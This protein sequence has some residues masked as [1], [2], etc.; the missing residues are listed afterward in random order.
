[1]TDRITLLRTVSGARLTKRWVGGPDKLEI[2]GYEDAKT[3]CVSEQEVHGIGSLSLVLRNNA[4]NYDRCVIRGAYRPEAVEKPSNRALRNTESTFDEPHHWCMIDVDGYEP[5]SADPVRE[6]AEAAAEFILDRLPKQFHDRSFYWQLSSSAGAPGNEGVLKAHLWFWLSEKCDSVALRSWAK[7]TPGVDPAV[8]RQVQPHYIADPVFVGVADPVPCRG[9]LVEGVLGDTVDI[10]FLGDTPPVQPT[11]EDASD[12]DLGKIKG[13]VPDYDIDRVRDEVLAHLDP[14]MHHDEWV[15][16]GM[17]LHHQFAGDPEALELWDEWS[18]DGASYNE[19]V[20]A[21]RWRSFKVDRTVG[22]GSVTLGSL[23]KQVRPK[24]AAVEVAKETGAAVSEVVPEPSAGH[25]NRVLVGLARLM[26]IPDADLPWFEGAIGWK[27]KTFEDT[28]A[29]IAWD[30]AR[31]RYNVLAPAADS[32]REFSEKQFGRSLRLLGMLDFYDH[33]ALDQVAVAVVQANM[34][35]AAPRPA[36]AVLGG[37]VKADDKA[38][39]WLAADAK[40]FHE[41]V[42][43]WFLGH[44]VQLAETHRQFKDCDETE[45]IY[46]KRGAM[47]VRKRR[48][49]ARFPMAPLIEGPEPDAALIDDFRQ[50]F[51]EFDDFLALLCAARLANDRK[52]AYLWLHAESNWGKGFLVG[53]LARLGVVAEVTMDDLVRA[54]SG[55]P[56][57]M[58]PERMRQAWVL[59]VNEFKGVTSEVKALENTISFSPKNRPMVTVPVYTKLF[60]SAEDV[61]SLLGS[62]TGADAQF[63]NRFMRVVGKGRLDDRPLFS[64]D[65]EKYGASIRGHMARVLNAAVRGAREQGR[66]MA[67]SAAD[68]A[69]RALHE[70]HPLLGVTDGAAG[71]DGPPLTLEQRLPE[72]AGQFVADMVAG[73]GGGLP[74]GSAVARIAR[75]NT[76]VK[77]GVVYLQRAEKALA[78][79]LDASFTPSEGGK[80]KYKRRQILDLIGSNRAC[81]DDAGEVRK[82]IK[83]RATGVADSHFME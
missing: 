15:A 17:A 14:N 8:F 16:V 66:E 55:A 61:P 5:L 18:S 76:F 52:Q 13:A 79:W 23:I 81:R 6:P 35:S 29:R 65:K 39:I 71:S 32:I 27:E 78:D 34:S 37:Q 46:T 22:T 10:S 74:A 64:A 48:M 56:S 75:D 69:L 36:I 63:A 7:Q 49:Q 25:A 58:T 50:H 80:V 44:L 83:L 57:G 1:M 82:A 43:G 21:E 53:Q 4:K 33:K 31:S 77:D 19:D 30:T 28:L 12:I 60:T 42:D 38:T 2:E 24:A 11:F 26:G 70:R 20:C 40:K 45:D 59:V 3:F 72:I 54:A 9:G 51:P 73:G 62:E 68:A 47:R 41:K 67:A